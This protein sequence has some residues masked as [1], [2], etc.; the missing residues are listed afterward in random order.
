LHIDKETGMSGRTKLLF[1]TLAT[2]ALGGFLVVTEII[3]PVHRGESEK[4][5]THPASS[6][7]PS[8]R[9]SA[10]ALPE[11][12]AGL[13]AD[14]VAAL[15]WSCVLKAFP[16]RADAAVRATACSKA[17]QTRQL[18]PD[19]IAL[20]RLT[21]GVARSL[22]GNIDLA[23]EDYLE[24]VQHYDELID[25]GN[26]D[27]LALFRRAVA[28]NA[29]GQ[30]DKALA[31]YTAAIKADPKASFAFLERG[32]L[33]ATRKRAYDRAIEDFNKV[34][35]LEP[36]NVDALIARG[37][38][39]SNLGD[40][41]LAMVD[42]NRA[43]ALAPDRATPY[44]IRGLA[45]ARQDNRSAARRDYEASLSINPRS[46]DAHVNLA[47]LDL[48]EGRHEAAVRELDQAISIHAVN[49]LAFYNRGYARFAL[50]QYDK[51]I[52]DYG[53]AIRLEPRFG[54]AYNN[55]ALVRAILGRDLVQALA[56]SDQALKLL[57]INRDV[58]ETRGFIFLRLGDPALALHEYNT[59]LDMDPNQAVSL[60]GRGLAKIKL[61]DASGGK[62][63]Q[64]AAL[65]INPD[66]EREFSGYGL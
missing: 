64:A 17:L 31:D 66:V 35:K 15:Y 20:A 59:V 65:A 61:G 1:V 46:A 42:L 53:T 13:D 3:A 6:P 25:S 29:S 48:L 4:G 56:D 7:S 12:S 27:A 8:D 33:L 55:R 30:S 38:A 51:A 62:L 18:R 32:V 9:A 26:P 54:R 14:A 23:S 57:P 28:L 45:E 37:D 10:T 50:K 2:L 49:P 52:T 47:A 24:A 39:F 22:L 11:P 60:Y 41:G 19:Q 21:R 5:P 44:L 40:P 36:D 34:L 16:N 63:D 58:R 43:V